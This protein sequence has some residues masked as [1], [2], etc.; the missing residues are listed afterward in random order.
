M[1][2][3]V[4]SVDLPSIR[5]WVEDGETG[6]LVDEENTPQLSSAIER[7]LDMSAEEAG[8]VTGEVYRVNRVEMD[9]EDQMLLMERNRN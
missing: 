1:K 5:E 4:M 2:R 6:F 3:P 9:A 7:V 8:A